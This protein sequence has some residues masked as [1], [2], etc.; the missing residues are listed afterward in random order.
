M[1][2]KLFSLLFAGLLCFQT[3]F[4][5]AEEEWLWPVAGFYNISSGFGQRSFSYHKGIDIAG[6]EANIIKDALILASKS[7]TVIETG[8]TCSHNYAKSTSCGCG[9][10]YGNY[11][12]IQHEDR[13]VS[14]YG[15]MSHVLAKPG[16]IVKQGDILGH[17]GSTG[18]SSGFH[19]HFEIRDTEDTPVNP[20]PENT[21]KL[22]TYEGSSAPLSESIPYKYAST[23]SHT[24]RMDDGSFLT[25]LTTDTKNPVLLFCHYS[26]EQLTHFEAHPYVSTPIFWKAHDP[27]ETVRIYMLQDSG[28]RTEIEYITFKTSDNAMDENE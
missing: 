4:A 17:V 28:K 13:T 27:S 10:G 9:D 20:M 12:Y 7:G 15:H 19:L 25:T 21:D 6:P 24:H 16:Q 23:F 14:R 2:K 3:V 26:N 22:H 8:E 11:V 18:S 1:I 5:E